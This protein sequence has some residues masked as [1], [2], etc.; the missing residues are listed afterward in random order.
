MLCQTQGLNTNTPPTSTPPHAQSYHINEGPMFVTNDGPFGTS[1]NSYVK[2]WGTATLTS[3]MSTLKT[4]VINL[5][6]DDTLINATL[7]SVHAT[8]YL[9][10]LPP[11][12]GILQ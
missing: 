9:S 10:H 1:E 7:S 5:V 11:S 12:P 8:S 3:G 6:M 2:L 4:S